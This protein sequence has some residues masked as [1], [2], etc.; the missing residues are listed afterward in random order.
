LGGGA[1]R[2][3]IKDKFVVVEESDYNFYFHYYGTR[4]DYLR[5][6][7]CVWERKREREHHE[8]RKILCNTRKYL[9]RYTRCSSVIH[10]ISCA[11]S[12][13]HLR[14]KNFMESFT[15]MKERFTVME[16]RYPV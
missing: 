11:W 1:C 10:T 6:R 2:Y 14:K 8:E 13:A 7:V 9:V 3:A 12:V 16:K 4:V 5:E 15:V